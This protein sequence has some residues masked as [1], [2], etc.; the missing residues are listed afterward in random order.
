MA[1]LSA[2]EHYRAAITLLRGSGLPLAGD[3]WLTSAVHAQGLWHLAMAQA[4][5]GF[6]RT[7]LQGDVTTN[8]APELG[9]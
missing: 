7:Q 3:A 1:K 4:I 8:N 6:G 2:H 9:R 5:E